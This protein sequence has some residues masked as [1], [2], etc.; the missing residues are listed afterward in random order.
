ML[1]REPARRATAQELLRHPFLKLAGPPSC[2]VPLMRQYRHHWAQ[3]SQRWRS[4][5]RMREQVGRMQ[6]TAEHAAGLRAQT[7]WLMTTGRA[8]QTGASSCV[9]N[10]HLSTDSWHA[11]LGHGFNKSL[12]YF[13]AFHPANQKDSVQTPLW[14]ILATCR[15]MHRIFYIERILFWQKKKKRKENKKHFFLNGSG[16]MYFAMNL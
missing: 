1:V 14:Y 15:V 4:E 8:R 2:I 10:R 5:M 13:S 16:V 3:E 12:L 6:G 7:S 11:H 9:F